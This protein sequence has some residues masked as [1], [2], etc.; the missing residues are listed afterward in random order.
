M[1]TRS[2]AVI[3]N[4][5]TGIIKTIITYILQFVI[6]TILVYTLGVEYVGLNGLF[7]NILGCLSLAELGFGTAIVVSL[8]KPVAENDE[9]T[10]KSLISMYSKV[11]AII[12]ATIFVV[13]LAIMPFIRFLIRTGIP[14]GIN[15]YIIYLLLLLNTVISYFSANRRSLLFVYQ[16]NDVE[17]NIKTCCTIIMY[18]LQVIALVLFKNYYVYMVVLPIMTAIESLL[19][20]CVT[21]KKYAFIRGKAQKLPPNV[22]QEVITNVKALSW[23]QVGGVLVLCTDNIIISAMLGG[24]TELGV[25]ANYTMITTCILSLINILINSFQAGIGNLLAS[26]N[27]EKTYNKFRQINFLFNFIVSFCTICIFVLSQDFILVWLKSTDCLLPTSTL[28]LICF[29]FYFSNS[30]IT[31]NMYNVALGLVR[32]NVWKPFCQGVIN[33]VISI[34]LAKYIGL[35]GVIIGTIVSYLLMPVWVEPFT[36]FKYYFKRG[37][38]QYF[39][40]FLLS[41]IFTV[42]S[43][44]I[45][46]FVCSFLPSGGIGLLILRFMVCGIT[47]AVSLLLFF[48]MLP[49]FKQCVAWGKEILKNFKNRDINTPVVENDKNLETQQGKDVSDLISTTEELDKIEGNETEKTSENNEVMPDITE[50]ALI[51]TKDHGEY[52]NCEQTKAVSDTGALKSD[53][54][55]QIDD[56][57]QSQNRS[58]RKVSKTGKMNKIDN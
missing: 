25:Y 34:L 21:N 6:R 13:G 27:I 55:K 53:M 5:K 44:S 43:G 49:E 38:S 47:C 57:V 35:A 37:K 8:Y 40:Q 33:L 48:C 32:Y 39:I 52:K 36:I 30:V 29:S 14:T 3:R 24:L 11:Y 56:S 26:E 31:P 45:T 1:L 22:K 58:A 15:I 50:P 17:N 41:F 10:V 18:A 28:L 19:I 9:N 42:L 54:E 2:K 7:S 46:F 12:S 51:H 4:A 20:I 23:H 16:R